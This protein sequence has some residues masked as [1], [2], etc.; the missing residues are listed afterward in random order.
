MYGAV[1]ALLER[2]VPDKGGPG[3]S[4]VLAD[5]F[6]IL[7]FQLPPGTIVGTQA[8]SMH[9]D[10]DIFPDPEFFNPERWLP[11]EKDLHRSEGLARL[12]LIVSIPLIIP[13]LSLHLKPFRSFSWLLT[14]G[15][16]RMFQHLM[17]F[18]AGTRACPGRY[19]AQ[20]IFRAAIAALAV[21][22]D[23]S[24]NPLETNVDTMAPR[25]A[26]VRYFMHTVPM[27]QKG[28]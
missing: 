25:D 4:S 7:G 6:D 19:Q 2:V 9:R 10:P 13:L 27:E 15:P 5:T 8:W 17:P 21:N 12:V 22:F 24:A 16:Y 26:F 18:G 14:F 20:L 23:L 1:S 28:S 11:C 3:D